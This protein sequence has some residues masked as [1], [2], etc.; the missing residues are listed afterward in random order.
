MTVSSAYAP[1]EFSATAGQTTKSITFPFGT[2]DDIV[3]YVNDVLE[4]DWSIS[5]TTLTFDDALAEGDDVFIGRATVVTQTTDYISGAPFASA[6]HE[7]ALDK[8]TRILQDHVEKFRRTPVLPL[9]ST[10]DSGLDIHDIQLPSPDSLELS[11]E[12]ARAAIVWNADNTNLELVELTT[13]TGLVS[14]AVT[15]LVAASLPAVGTSGRLRYLTNTIRG[16]HADPGSGEW[17]K[18]AGYVCN[19]AEFGAVGDG[20][21]EDTDAIQAALDA[22]SD[23]GGGVVYMP[24]GTYSVDTLY[25]NDD[26]S[27]VGSGMGVTILSMIAHATTHNPVIL[28]GDNGGAVGTGSPAGVGNGRVVNVTV[29]DLSING[30]ENDQTGVGDQFSPGIMIWG[31][32]KCLVERCEIYDCQG[33]AV[34]LGYGVGRVEAANQN[35]IR[36]CVFYGNARQ[37]IALT[38]GAENIFAYNA[39]SG[40]IDLELDDTLGEIRK[41]VIIG[42]TGRTTETNPLTEGSDLSIS[43]AT[44]NTDETAYF[45]NVITNNVIEFLS[46]GFN[47]ATII[48]NNIFVGSDDSRVYMASLDGANGTLLT[49]NIFYANTAV[50]TSLTSVIRTRGGAGI[51]ITNNLVYNDAISF[52]EY[53]STLTDADN[54]SVHIFRDNTLMGTGRYWQAFSERIGEEAI[55][56]IIADGATP[57]VFT[58]DQISGVPLF[59]GT[60]TGSSPLACGPLTLTVSAATMIFTLAGTASW[61][62]EPLPYGETGA[63]TEPYDEHV[64]ATINEDGTNRTVAA[65][66]APVGAGGLTYVQFSFADGGSDGTLFFK[67]KY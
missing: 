62:I 27:L 24:P 65:F 29:R 18:V 7:N 6:S 23:A 17:Y 43:L 25:I 54:A 66:A 37:Q 47:F 63:G 49:G 3:V 19:V 1:I 9:T 36:N 50:A 51:Q 48:S 44:L 15:A 41:N 45:G 21:T 13:E 57:Q 16:L 30:N 26:V 11:D 53:I 64:L 8:I 10:F 32:D 14:S 34:W 52:V 33:D 22:A 38:Y 60:K 35:V 56:R 40:A 61:S 39:I 42:N 28:I 55:I 5:G 67:I 20:V 46:L 2:S 12:D 4:T 31:S 58:V 59:T